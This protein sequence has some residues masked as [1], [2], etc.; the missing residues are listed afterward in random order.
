METGMQNQ[1]EA[2]ASGHFPLY[3]Y[4]PDRAREGENP[5]TLD[6]KPPTMRFSEHA[7]KENRFRVLK[8]TNPAD[9]ER[10]MAEAD[11][12]VAAR[13]ALYEKL[14]ALP[15]CTG[16]PAETELPSEPETLS[17]PGAAALRPLPPESEA[18]PAK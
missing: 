3:R 1:K 10:L 16:M 9:A 18:P 13:Y 5:L 2:V 4:N 14:A 8:Q 11:R 17:E 15:L 6:S 12:L 7:M